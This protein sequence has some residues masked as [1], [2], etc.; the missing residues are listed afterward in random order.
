MV[1]K[2]RMASLEVSQIILMVPAADLGRL[3]G[4][5]VQPQGTHLRRPASEQ[6]RKRVH[7]A[8]LMVHHVGAI[9]RKACNYLSHW[10]QGNRRR[11][12]RP[13]YYDF[14][15]NQVRGASPPNLVPLGLEEQC[16]GFFLWLW[17]P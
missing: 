11:L 14:L 16:H 8:A 2:D 1:V 10:A 17:V 3:Q 12:P 5:P 9:S 4:L 6:D 7:E 15:E 13:A